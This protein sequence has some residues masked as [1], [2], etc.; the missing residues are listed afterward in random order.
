MESGHAKPGMHDRFAERFHQLSNRD[1]FL[2]V[3]RLLDAMQSALADGGRIE[4]R[5][6]GSFSVSRVPARSGRNPRTGE[7]VSVP[8]K[9]LPDFKPQRIARRRD[10]SVSSGHGDRCRQRARHAGSDRARCHRLMRVIW[11]ITTSRFAAS[12]FDGEGARL[13]GGRRNP[14]GWPMI[15]TAESQSLALL[16]LMVQDD[17]LRANY[18]RI[19]AQVPVD[20]PETKVDAETLPADWRTIDARGALQEIGRAWLDSGRTTVLSVPSAMV[21]AER[22][23]LLNPRHPDFTRVQIGIPLSLEVDTRLLHNLA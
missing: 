20:L 1:V 23:D 17:P 10:A 22:N 15:Y 2:A 7:A 13:Y 5:R 12:A 21:P 19:P 6:F 4:I 14:K 3:A 16:E 8:A 11:R 18:V 9:C